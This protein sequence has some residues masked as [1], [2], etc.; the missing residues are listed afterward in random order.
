MLQFNDYLAIML[1]DAPT[2]AVYGPTGNKLYLGSRPFQGGFEDY[3]ERSL[4]DTSPRSGHISLLEDLVYYW[5]KQRPPDFNVRK[6]TLLSLSYHPLKIVAA[7]WVRYVDVLSLCIKQYEYSTEKHT[8]TKVLGKLNQDLRDLQSWIRR[9]IQTLQKLQAAIR[10]VKYRIKLESNKDRYNLI[11]DDYE[12][13][14]TGVKVWGSRLEA[15]VP[16]VTTLVQ[17]SDSRESLREAAN[18]RRLTNL[19]LLF[20]PLSFVTGLFS[21]ND[22]ISGRG[23]W[24]FFSVAAPLCMVTILT[25]HASQSNWNWF[26]NKAETMTRECKLKLGALKS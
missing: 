18:V 4:E 26:V 20:V 16:L 2:K 23:V 5:T 11:L 21:M 19:A 6:P 9:Y 3:L 22:N 13:L 7:E 1:V 14:T 15:M 24:L 8:E 12:Y 25:A 10:F 17:I